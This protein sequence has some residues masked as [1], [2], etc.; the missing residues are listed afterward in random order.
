MTQNLDASTAEC[1]VFTEKEGLLSG[2][3]HDL[4]LRVERFRL[5]IDDDSVDGVVCR[6]GY[7]LMD[8]P[9]A[10][11]SETRRVLRPG[12]RVALETELM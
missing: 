2:V 1:L 6:W 8:D 11:L 10:A 12:G 4:K 3:A 5:R 9:A 7:M